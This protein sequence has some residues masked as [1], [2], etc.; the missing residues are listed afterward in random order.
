[1][2]PNDQTG[3]VGVLAPYLVSRALFAVSCRPDRNPLPLPSNISGGEKKPG[4]PV[5]SI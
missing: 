5:L 4:S 2:R 3:L 1:M